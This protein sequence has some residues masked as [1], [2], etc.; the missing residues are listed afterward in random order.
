M[1]NLRQFRCH[2]RRGM[3]QLG[4]GNKWAAGPLRRGRCLGAGGHVWQTV[5]DKSCCWR[6]RRRPAHSHDRQGKLNKRLAK[7]RATFRYTTRYASVHNKREP[8]N[9]KYPMPRRRHLCFWNS[10]CKECWKFSG[11]KTS[12]I[13]LLKKLVLRI[14]GQNCNNCC[15]LT[16]LKYN[17][18]VYNV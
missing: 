15:R 14:L 11:D 18:H 5:G 9:E 2:R 8:T 6:V 12:R 13:V 1:W 10:C 17:E 16:E 7:C 4:N 3:L